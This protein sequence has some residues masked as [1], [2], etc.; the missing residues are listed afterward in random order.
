MNGADAGHC[1]HGVGATD[2]ATPHDP[3]A[4]KETQGAFLDAYAKR[5]NIQNA[6]KA[7]KSTHRETV[8]QD[9][10]MDRLYQTDSRGQLNCPPL[11]VIFYLKAVWRGKYGDNA[12]PEDS[13]PAELLKRLDAM[14]GDKVKAAVTEDIT[15]N[16]PLLPGAP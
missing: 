14:S 1:E 7:A 3:N 6:A 4:L 16:K 8:E 13:A 9:V 12:K 5:G 2:N 15:S 11:L 10:L